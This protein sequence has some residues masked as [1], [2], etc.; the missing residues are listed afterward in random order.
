KSNKPLEAVPNLQRVLLRVPT[1]RAG[2]ETAVH[3]WSLLGETYLG[4]GEPQEA[5]NAF[6][7]AAALKP[8]ASI[9]LAVARAWLAANRPALASD[10]AEKALA[11]SPSAAAWLVLASAQLRAQA[12]LAP[13]DR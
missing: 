3:A 6:Q 7:R 1:S 8:T 2:Y 12:A 10:W 4:L 9:H 5:A 11:Q 13:R